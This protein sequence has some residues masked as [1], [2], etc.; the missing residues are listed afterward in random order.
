MKTIGVEVK[1]ALDGVRVDYTGLPHRLSVDVSFLDF[2]LLHYYLFQR[3][4]EVGTTHSS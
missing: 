3:R 2:L 1:T 4:V